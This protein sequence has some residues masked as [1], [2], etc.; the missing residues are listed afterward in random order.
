M[1]DIYRLKILNIYLKYHKTD[2]QVISTV[3]KILRYFSTCYT[4]RTN[5]TQCRLQSLSLKVLH[6]SCLPKIKHVH[7]LQNW[8]FQISL[9]TLALPRYDNWPDGRTVGKTVVRS[10]STSSLMMAYSCQRH[11]PPSTDT[12]PRHWQQCRQSRLF[13][14]VRALAPWTTTCSCPSPSLCRESAPHETGTPDA[15]CHRRQTPCFLT[16]GLDVVQ[17]WT[18]HDSKNIK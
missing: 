7:T 9:H 2:Y 18:Q 5:V 10:R 6:C 11:C 4:V 15:L 1:L 14:R 8:Q 12:S 13:P 17:L 3:S 16:R